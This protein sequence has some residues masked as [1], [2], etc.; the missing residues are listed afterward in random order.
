MRAT[1]E[2]PQASNRHKLVRLVYS[3][4][5]AEITEGRLA[6]DARL[7]Q[8]ELAQAYGVSRQPI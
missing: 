6:A 4:I 2:A 1:K 8:D 5:L 3:A 7:I